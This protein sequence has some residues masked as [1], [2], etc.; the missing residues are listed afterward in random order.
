[1]LRSLSQVIFD[2]PQTASAILELS[3]MVKIRSLEHLGRER[4]IIDPRTVERLLR[5]S[6][7]HTTA[8]AP[9]D[10]TVNHSSTEETFYG[11]GGKDQHSSKSAL[12]QSRSD[13]LRLLHGSWPGQ[14]V[15]RRFLVA[16]GDS[17]TVAK[18]IS[19]CDKEVNVSVPRY[20]SKERRTV[21]LAILEI[22]PIR[23]ISESIT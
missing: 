5:D 20:V 4:G 15:A 6:D 9:F 7:I 8:P 18:S 23:A 19:A 1:M 13:R 14:D 16:G 2:N 17:G 21:D 22:M 11:I 12:Y 10:E 3:P